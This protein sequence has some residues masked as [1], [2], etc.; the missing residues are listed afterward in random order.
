MQYAAFII[1]ILP[2][3]CRPK[4][5]KGMFSI[6]VSILSGSLVRL[7]II[8]PMPMTPPSSIVFGTRNSS[9]AKAAIIEPMVSIKNSIKI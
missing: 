6:M 7:F 5:R 8:M 9:M 2:S 3:L 4:S 1:N